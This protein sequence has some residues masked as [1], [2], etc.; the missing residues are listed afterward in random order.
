MDEVVRVGVV[1]VEV[2]RVEVVRVD[3][4]SDT[5]LREN[6]EDDCVMLRPHVIG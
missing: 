5:L 2:E 1:R 6:D 3:F 4:V